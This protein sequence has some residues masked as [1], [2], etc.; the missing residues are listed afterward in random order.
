MRRMHVSTGGIGG[1]RNGWM[2]KMGF[3]EEGGREN[4]KGGLYLYLEQSG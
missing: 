4:I 2:L 1:E 3:V